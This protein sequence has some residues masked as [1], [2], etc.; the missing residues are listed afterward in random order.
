M[1]GAQSQKTAERLIKKSNRD[2][3]EKLRNVEK[4]IDTLTIVQRVPLTN[5]IFL[6]SK[7]IVIL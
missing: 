6:E 5:Q 4:L 3:I 7:N 1:M 2:N